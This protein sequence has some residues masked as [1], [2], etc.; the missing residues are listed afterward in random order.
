MIHS[1]TH[2][3]DILANNYLGVD[4]SK[5]EV[6]PFLGELKELIGSDDYEAFTSAQIDRDHGRYHLTAINVAEYNRLAKHM[7]I[8]GFVNSLD[9]ILKYEIDDL[10]ML[11][12]GRAEKGADVA[13]FVVC[14][15]EK[16]DA[17]RE[18]YGLD[19]KDLHITLGFKHRDV[20]G[21]RKNEVLKK[22]GKFIQ[23]LGQE[24]YKMENWNF[25]KDISGFDSDRRA[26]ILPVEISDTVAKFRCGGDYIGVAYIEDGENFRIVYKYAVDQALP[27]IPDTEIARILKG[28]HLKK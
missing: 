3:K 9:P 22:S 19:K 21:V 26:D 1:I 5:D 18:R 23:L 24:F 2:L 25:V 12:L 17:I 14:R 10:K 15:S 8:D 6:E 20:F 16:I 27:K 4:I 13:F 28:K 11:G 7:G